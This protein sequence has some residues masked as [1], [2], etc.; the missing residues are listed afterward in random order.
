MHLPQWI[1]LALFVVSAGA[2]A[3]LFLLA[4]RGRVRPVVRQVVLLWIG[5]LAIVFFVSLA[6]NV[7]PAGWLSP[8]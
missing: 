3:V 7:E 1:L 2:Y 8:R 5:L 6:V 4:R